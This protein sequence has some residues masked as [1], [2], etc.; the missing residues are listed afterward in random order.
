[1]NRAKTFAA[2][3]GL[4]VATAGAVQGAEHQPSSADA[5]WLTT[6]HQYGVLQGKGARVAPDLGTPRA[7]LEAEPI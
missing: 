5:G 7:Q 1:M 3:L 2:I 6:P 4:T